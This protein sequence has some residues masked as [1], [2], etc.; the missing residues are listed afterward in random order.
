MNNLLNFN[1]CTKFPYFSHTKPPIGGEKTAS[2]NSKHG[3]KIS[4]VYDTFCFPN[5]L[6]GSD[7]NHTWIAGVTNVWLWLKQQCQHV[8]QTSQV[9]MEFWRN[10]LW[11]QNLLWTLGLYYCILVTMAFPISNG[12][13]RTLGLQGPTT[14]TFTKY[15]IFV[16]VT[17]SINITLI[18]VYFFSKFSFILS[19]TFNFNF[20]LLSDSV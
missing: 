15:N 1:F 10:K 20:Y 18:S 5:L 2:V 16:P 17:Y 8:D 4:Y 3:I 12:P 7:S 9:I 6:V 14:E 19:T 11:K 13:N